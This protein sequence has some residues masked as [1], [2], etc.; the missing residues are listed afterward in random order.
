M[1]KYLFRISDTLLIAIFPHDSKYLFPVLSRS[2]FSEIRYADKGGFISREQVGDACKGLLLH[3]DV[4]RYALCGS[5][6]GSPCPEPTEKF[7][8]EDVGRDFHALFS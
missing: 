3:Y 2:Y 8:M 6:G 7:R 5:R 4:G 1:R